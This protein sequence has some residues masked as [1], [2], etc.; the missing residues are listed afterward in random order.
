MMSTENKTGGQMAKTG[1]VDASGQQHN[2]GQ[3]AQNKKV[4]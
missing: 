2:V 1:L 3:G 4:I